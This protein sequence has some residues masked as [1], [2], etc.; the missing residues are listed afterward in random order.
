VVKG[1]KGEYVKKLSIALKRRPNRKTIKRDFKKEKKKGRNERVGKGGAGK[2]LYF[3]SKDL[4][5][6]I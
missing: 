1:G 2:N 5:K 4:R 6:K 3:K